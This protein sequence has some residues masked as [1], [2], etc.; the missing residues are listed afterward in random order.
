M[1]VNITKATQLAQELLAVLQDVTSPAAPSPGA[2]A[3][4]G[5]Q[6]VNRV[7][8][9]VEPAPA[10]P[11]G[12]E[13]GIVRYCKFQT[14]KGGKQ[15]LSLG[16][17]LDPNEPLKFIQVW[18]QT[19]QERVHASENWRVHYQ[20]KPSRDGRDPVFVADIYKA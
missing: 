13:C 2:P 15:Y 11:A 9:G 1:A 16:I 19:L 7:P 14:S 3:R 6:A 18:D 17:A 20:L 8:A 12:Y 10:V 4:G 5:G